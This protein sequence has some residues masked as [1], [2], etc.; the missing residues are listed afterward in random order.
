MINI[1]S[2]RNKTGLSQKE[3][4]EKYKISVR[5]LQQWEQGI[6]KPLDSLI[7]LINKDINN[8]SNLRNMYKHS[9]TKYKVCIE[10]PFK[11]IE[12]IY[13]IQQRKVKAIIDDLKKDKQVLKII[14][15]GSSTTD[16]CHIGSDVDIYFE[17]M[18]SETKLNK[19]YDFEYD[20]WNNNTVD[21]RLKNE[22]NK[23]GVI[24]Y[25]RN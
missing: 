21:E 8:V 18:N 23:K 16:R 24:V 22:I 7:F 5:T 1:K 3:F 10:K 6:S 20:L 17:S 9:R 19:V 13:P 11:N 15:F 4:A 2:L 14:V 25:E 12:M